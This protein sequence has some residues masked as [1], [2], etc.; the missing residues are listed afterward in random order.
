MKRTS[1]RSILKARFRPATRHAAISVMVMIVL[2]LLSSL[3]LLQV[4]RVLTDRRQSRQEM[5]SLQA[6]HL[7]E[8]G[9]MRASMSRLRTPD[10]PGE[11]WEIPSGIIHQ[12]NSA[13]VV[14]ETDDDNTCRVVARYPANSE[15]PVQVTRSRRL[16]Q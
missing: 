14:I 12:T 2:L 1:L 16:I 8:A 5:L 3:V 7:A 10:Y 15:T 9:L 6:Q 4:R 11:V 13:T